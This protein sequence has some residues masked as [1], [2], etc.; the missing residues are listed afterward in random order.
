M[1]QAARVLYQFPISHYCE[2]TRWN[3]DAKG[4]SYR[5]ENLVPGLHMLTTRRLGRVG[6]VPVLA[7]GR[8]LVGDST[9][10]AA[11]LERAYP[12]RPLLPADDAAR[13]RA[14][15]LEAYFGKRAGRAVRQWLY[16]HIGARPG[17]MAEVVF[18]GY[19]PTTQRIAALA[20]PLLERA[21][22]KSYRL[23]APGVARARQTI[24]EALDRLERETG[25][26]PL[27]YLAGDALSIA[28]IAAAALLGPLVA[29][30]E[31][32]WAATA[33]GD[34]TPEAV[35]ALRAE[36]GARPAWA[37]VRERYARDRR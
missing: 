28:D 17:A 20:A 34:R 26:D 11:H 21:M 35:A 8:T 4:L 30:P 27:R 31:S 1:T 22:R 15:E 32:P 24:G 5:V 19:P 36:L 6:T 14:L 23:D 33:T 12:D 37:W 29:A 10:I 16:G 3:L 9:A 2:K 7:D 13:A 18:Q 25:G